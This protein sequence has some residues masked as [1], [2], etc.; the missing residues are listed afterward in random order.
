MRCTLVLVSSSHQ[1]RSDCAEGG[2]NKPSRARLLVS[3]TSAAKALLTEAEYFTIEVESK[4]R[5]PRWATM[6]EGCAHDID[7][8]LS[9]VQFS[10]VRGDTHALVCLGSQAAGLLDATQPDC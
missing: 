9:P 2:R 6:T 8:C 5:R 1:A 4:Y 7:I 10:R 3:S